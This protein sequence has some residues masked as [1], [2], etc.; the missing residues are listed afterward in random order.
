[1]FLQS[2]AMML[3]SG[4]VFSTSIRQEII[5]KSSTVAELVGV[6]DTM[7][8][9]LWTRAFLEDQGH[10]VRNIKKKSTKIT[11]VQ[12][13]SGPSLVMMKPTP[14]SKSGTPSYLSQ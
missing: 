5:T 14:L 2:E 13:R 10:K 7:G 12:N 3:G 8:Q 6:H 1:M 9:V 11:K 4:A